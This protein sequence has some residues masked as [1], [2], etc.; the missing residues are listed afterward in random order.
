M[1][2]GGGCAGLSLALKLAELGEKSPKVLIIEQR[3]NYV[4]D[5]TWCF[6]DI[7]NPD[8]KSLAQHAW[9][10]FEI[11]NKNNAHTHSCAANQYLMLPS[12][13]FYQH[14]ITSIALNPN[15]EL[16]TGQE[17]LADPVKQKNVWHLNTETLS[18]SAQLVVDTRPPKN[19]VDTD[20]T[21]WQSFVGYEIEV[22]SAQF[23]PDKF[24]LM[25]FDD[26]FSNGTAFIYFLPTSEQKALIEYT[27]FS[28]KFMP[29]HILIPLL[30]QSLLEY[31]ANK[32]HKVLRVEHGILPMGNKLLPQPIDKTYIFA[33]LFAGAARPSSG[34]AFQRIQAWAKS[35]S[36]AI[37]NESKLYAFQK[38][39][40]MK[41]F[42]DELFL[43]VIKTNHTRAASLFEALFKN[44]NITTA[45]KFLSDR[46]N[47]V[48]NFYIIKSMPQLPFIKAIPRFLFEKISLKIK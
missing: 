41:S 17:I 6:W 8:Y 42:M 7:D 3:L 22:D 12:D 20:A 32:P 1:I 19:V 21:L 30:E 5:K 44:C 45:I 37:V 24:V 31:T 28:E 43:T 40:F 27:V 9:E 14:A 47:M 33:G 46:A 34:Y 48:D 26:S 15:I 18:C 35:C 23:A 39:G 38:D 16:L 4:N 36:T 13:V 2:I 25:D 11:R 29:A 10:K